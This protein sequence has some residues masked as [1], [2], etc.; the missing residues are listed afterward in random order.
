MGQHDVKTIAPASIGQLQPD[1]VEK[2]IPVIT[3]LPK[4]IAGRDA[5]IVVQ[6]GIRDINTVDFGMRDRT[7]DIVV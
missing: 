1:M 2:A 5:S 6:T 4:Q 7:V 3:G